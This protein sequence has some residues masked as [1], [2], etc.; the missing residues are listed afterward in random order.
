MVVRSGPASDEEWLFNY[1]EV[2]RR[3]GSVE[4]SLLLTK[5]LGLGGH[6]SSLSAG[7]PMLVRWRAWINAGA[8]YLAD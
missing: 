8:P 5:P 7:S 2:K 3:G 4:S 1:E 6:P